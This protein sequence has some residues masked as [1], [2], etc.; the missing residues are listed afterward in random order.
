[1]AITGALA[2]VKR[3]GSLT[4]RRETE[5]AFRRLRVGMWPVVQTAVAAALAWSA[6]VIVLGYER[7]FVA[8][9]AAVISVGAVAGQTLKLA[10]ECILGV[11]VGLAVADLIMLARGT[12]PIQTGVIVA[13]VMSAALLMSGG[14]MFV[15]EAG[16]TAV[17]VA[18]LDPA[19]YGVS[20]DRFLEA[21]VGGGVALA[22]RDTRVLARAAVTLVREK[23]TAS[24]ELTEAILELALAGYLEQRD[25]PLDVR[26]FALGATQEAAFALEKNND[27][28]TSVLVGQIRSTAMDLLR[29]AGM[30]SSEALEALRQASRTV[31]AA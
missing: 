26:H 9:I 25:H 21:L 15:T 18:G 19:T 5:R 24:G 11:A 8:A 16:V 2:G 14:A 12:G 10:A 20:P 31:S 6:A 29:A 4:V 22:V 1:M 23:G 3:V 7:P 28:E 30:G 13:L 17:L 27:L